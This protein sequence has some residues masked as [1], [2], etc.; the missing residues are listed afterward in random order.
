[1]LPKKPDVHIPLDFRPIAY[2]TTLLKL[3]TV[4]I[5]DKVYAQC[6]QNN[7]LTEEQNIQGFL[8][9]QFPVLF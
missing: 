7:I 9:D 3:L 6:E 2:L 5:S 4:V 8:N 1:M